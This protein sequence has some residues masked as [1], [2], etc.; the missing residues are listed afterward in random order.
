LPHLLTV[1]HHYN[2]D[3]SPLAAFN[4]GSDCSPNH[5]YDMEIVI[6]ISFCGGWASA[7]SL[8]HQWL[9]GHMCTHQEN[10]S[11]THQCIRACVCAVDRFGPQGCPGTCEAF[12]QNNPG[13][14]GEAFWRFNSIKVYQYQ[15]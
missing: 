6:N 2:H 9:T 12:V 11:A 15:F 5:F 7:C 10:N 14:F 4:M 3:N 13:S 8:P 1:Y